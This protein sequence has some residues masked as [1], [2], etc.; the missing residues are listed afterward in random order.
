MFESIFVEMERR[1]SGLSQLQIAMQS[2]GCDGQYGERKI[3]SP[4]L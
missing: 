4:E 2:M 3:K 1:E